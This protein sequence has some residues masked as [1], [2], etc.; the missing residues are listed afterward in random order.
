VRYLIDTNIILELRKGTRCDRNVASWF[1]GLAED[2]IFLSVL[3]IGE[4]RAG[5]DR[6]QRRDRPRAATLDRWLN[7]LTESFQERILPIDREIAEEWGRSNVPDPLPVI[8]G[9]LAATARR[10]RLSVATRNTRDIAR[11][12]VDCI[13][14]FEP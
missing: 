6:I 1:A 8:D 10:H 13:N 2:E 9:L 11:A 7:G 4:I 14:P 3:I 12:G 5:I